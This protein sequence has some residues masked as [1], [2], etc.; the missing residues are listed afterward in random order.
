MKLQSMNKK[1][2]LFFLLIGVFTGG[3]KKRGETKPVLNK[4]LFPDT[5]GSFQL[6]GKPLRNRVSPNHGKLES[7]QVFFE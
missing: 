2:L 1:F 4:A 7:R 5:I 6:S 3:C